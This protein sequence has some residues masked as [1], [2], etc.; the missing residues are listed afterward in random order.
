MIL[1]L[2]QRESDGVTILE[3]EGRI[4]VGESSQ[5]FHQEVRAV[6]AGGARKLV[7]QLGGITYIDSSGVGE[8]VGALTAAK[9]AGGE[10]RLADLT[11]KVR[12]LM[13]MT[14]LNKLFELNYTEAAAVQALK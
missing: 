9:N 10:L 5:K 2:Q 14:N 3:M 12:D 1:N 8:I 7:L 6:I 11:P 4:L 13:K